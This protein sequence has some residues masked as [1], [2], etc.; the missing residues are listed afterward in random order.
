MLRNKKGQFFAI[1][2]VLLTL[3]MCG[4]A[5]FLY[6]MQ[7]KNVGNSMV[8]P[9]TLLDL[10]DKQEIF[11]L[12][13]KNIVLSASKESGLAINQDLNIFND[14][15]IEF[16]MKPEQED[17]RS[18]IFSNMTLDGKVITEATVASPESRKAVFETRGIYLFSIE[19]S[20]LKVE[21]KHVGKSFVLRA[22]NKKDANFISFVD[23]D[24]SRAYLI[25]FD[26]INK[27]MPK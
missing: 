20:A 6:Y 13:E 21:R 22:P 23:Y 9:T 10:K 14:K 25:D 16:V 26:E 27:Y 18:F 2:L 15:F 12:S 24:Y 5:I 8:S 4:M 19:N 3:F 7:S 11:D 17:F 1:Y